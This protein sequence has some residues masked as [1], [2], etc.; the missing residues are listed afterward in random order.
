M[1]QN[2]KYFTDLDESSI[3]A[4]PIQSQEYAENR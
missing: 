3:K 2:Q 4:A 1:I